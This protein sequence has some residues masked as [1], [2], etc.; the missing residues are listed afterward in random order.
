MLNSK[1]FRAKLIQANDGFNLKNILEVRSLIEILKND[2]NSLSMSG[3]E[4]ND[5]KPKYPEG[6][7]KKFQISISVKASS[8]S[9]NQQIHVSNTNQMLEVFIQESKL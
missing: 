9:L 4:S 7:L 6:I 8:E 2:D 5:E 3:W 1:G